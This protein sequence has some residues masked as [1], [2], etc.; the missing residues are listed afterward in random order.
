MNRSQFLISLT[1]WIPFI[2]GSTVGAQTPSENYGSGEAQNSSFFGK[3]VTLSS[4]HLAKPM[5]SSNSE[6]PGLGAT[7]PMKNF[8]TE[9][10][11]KNNAVA[12]D[13]NNVTENKDDSLILSSKYF[14]NEP[15]LK[16]AWRE[17]CE[18]KAAHFSEPA[19]YYRKAAVLIQMGEY[20]KAATELKNLI[21]DVPNNSD[22]H[23]AQAYCYF[24]LGMKTA[25]RDEVGTARFHNPRLP[26]NVSFQ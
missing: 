15:D 3:D 1:G 9:V 24:K 25:A 10:P 14:C 19:Y 6:A 11:V 12:A 5:H 17:V 18:Q 4:P 2:L 22:Y 20:Q 8:P 21:A 23:L 13:S 26:A 16:A 7:V